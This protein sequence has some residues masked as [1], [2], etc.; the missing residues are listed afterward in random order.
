MTELAYA[1]V[2]LV[3]VVNLVANVIVARASHYSNAQKAAQSA[4]IW[5]LPVVGALAVWIISSQVARESVVGQPSADHF[6]DPTAVAG[7]Y[8]Q[9]SSFGSDSEAG[10]DGD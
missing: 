9:G 10:G 4:L 8:S 3:V 2:A 5:L 7:S 6:A 1:A